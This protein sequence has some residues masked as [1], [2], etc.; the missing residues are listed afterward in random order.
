MIIVLATAFYVRT[1]KSKLDTKVDA[2]F[3]L[4]SNMPVIEDKNEDKRKMLRLGACIQHV[5]IL[6]IIQLLKVAYKKI[7]IEFDNTI[8]KQKMNN[9]FGPSF[10]DLLEVDPDLFPRLP[11]LPQATSP[12]KTSSRKQKHQ[13]PHK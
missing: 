1:I 11:R 6:N 3:Q 10:W 9:D 4:I 2:M 12:T 7:N 13:K 5:S 8:L